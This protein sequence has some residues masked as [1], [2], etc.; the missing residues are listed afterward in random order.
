M[1]RLTSLLTCSS[2]LVTGMKVSTPPVS[3]A[4]QPG[5]GGAQ[6]R[7]W[8]TTLITEPMLASGCC[9][10]CASAMPG[11]SACEPKWDGFRGLVHHSDGVCRVISRQGNDLTECFPDIAAAVCSQLPPET[12]VD[13][14]SWSS[15]ATTGSTSP[16][17]ANGSPLAD[18]APSWLACTRPP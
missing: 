16:H 15:G 5:R 3:L 4:P 1:R 2:G 9:F 6:Y 8:V 7:D 11:G 13:G 14:A 10:A 12:I 18:D 17:W